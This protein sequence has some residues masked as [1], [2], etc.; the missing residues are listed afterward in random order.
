[1]NL[2]IRLDGKVAI[3]TGSA[4]GIGQGMAQ[5]LASVGATVIVADIAD[6]AA[7]KTAQDI[8]ASGGKAEAYHLDTTDSSQYNALVEHLM[9]QYG[10][11]DILVNNAGIN[12]R[13]LCVNMPEEDFRKIIDIN[14]V[15][16]WIGCKAVAPVMIAQKSGK[17]VNT[18]SIMGY[19]SL[20]EL[21]AYS[22]SKG[23][24]LQL[25]RN[26]ALELVDHNIQV[27]A[28]APAYILTEMTEKLKN[29]TVMYD[30]LIRRTPMKRFGTLEEIA[31]PVVF[32]C[33]DLANFMTGHTMPVD[34]GWLCS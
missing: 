28:V 12:R 25:T 30:D 5:G 19:A 32:L 6:E 34:G 13:N 14:L 21:S 27:N 16:V 2:N 4:M 3:V 29:N 24:V 15:G 23:G 8:V 17:I 26:L 31:G 9:E 10:K 18:C 33:S 11:I 1:M 7:Q 20:P 22:A